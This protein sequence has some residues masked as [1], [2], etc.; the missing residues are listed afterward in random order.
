MVENFTTTI[1]CKSKAHCTTCRSSAEWRKAVGA[2]DICPWNQQPPALEESKPCPEIEKCLT[3][4]SL[5]CELKPLSNCGRAKRMKAGF[6][7]PK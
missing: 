2:P 6:K 3:C 4:P 7:C 5:T 1:H